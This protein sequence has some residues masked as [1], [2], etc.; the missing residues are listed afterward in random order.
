V[1]KKRLIACLLI[2]DGLIVQSLGFSRWLPIGRP[3]FPI[4]FVV[5]WDVDEIVLLDMSAT[6]EDRGPRADLLE[7][8][9]R[10]CY[11][12]LT[13][14]GGVRSVDDVRQAIQHGADKVCVNSHA[15][16]RP[17]LIGEIA[18]VYGN[19]CVVVSIDCRR[20]PDGSYQV[21]SRCGT[22]PTGRDAVEWARECERLGAG[23]IFLNS[24]DRDGSRLGYDLELVASVSK[25][26][27][28]PVIACGGIGNHAEFAA[29]IEAGADAVAAANIFHHIEHSTILAKAHMVA[30]GI[31]VRLDSEA[32]Y[33]GREFDETG[34]LLML[35]AE[36]LAGVEFRR[37]EAA[38]SAR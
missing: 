2:R 12:P 17:A 14:G 19:Q 30:S 18:S 10:Y 35:D 27:T 34:R 25:A 32:T 9:S 38:R 20:R 8:L 5:K 3:R 37:R 11:V 7:T 33:A 31:D 15:L 29:G 1:L 28:I 16:E 4:E 6:G 13:V 23:E 22:R 26:M 24:I 21:W 36:R